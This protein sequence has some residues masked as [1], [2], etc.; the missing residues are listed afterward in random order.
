VDPTGLYG[1]F[2]DS[3]ESGLLR[4]AWVYG[5]GREEVLGSFSDMDA[6]MAWAAADYTYGGRD[7]TDLWQRTGFTFSGY[8]NGN[9]ENGAVFWSVQACIFLTEGLKDAYDFEGMV[10]II[11]SAGVRWAPVSDWSVGPLYNPDPLGKRVEWNPGNGFWNFALQDGVRGPSWWNVPNLAA[12]AHEI[13]HAYDDATNRWQTFTKDDDIARE[14]WAMYHENVMRYAFY[15]RVPDCGKGG[16]HYTRPRPAYG[17]SNVSGYESYGFVPGQSHM[18]R[19]VSW[20]D[21]DWD[22]DAKP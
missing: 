7:E 2:L 19:D 10:H 6:W 11:E 13:G 12:L 1:K 15:R 5:D 18:H 16:R 8:T 14:Q 3:D 4:F 21:W 20:E 22:T 9:E 17:F